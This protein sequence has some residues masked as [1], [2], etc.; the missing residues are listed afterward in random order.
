MTRGRRLIGGVVASFGAVGAGSVASL[1]VAPVMFHH[2]GPAL[3]GVWVAVTALTSVALF[4]DLG[5]GNG[6]LTCLAAHRHAPAGATAPHTVAVA[7]LALAGTAAALLTGVVV[8]GVAV[9]V[10]PLFGV[11]DPTLG[12]RAA[13]VLV[14]CFGAF[15]VNLPLSLIAKIQLAMQDTARSAA[16][17]AGTAA[18]TVLTVGG[19]SAAGL[20][21]L[22]F[23]AAAATAAPIGNLVNT[24]HY[25]TWVRPDLRPR[26]WTLD[27]DLAGG[28]LRLSARYFTL[29][30]L[31]STASSIDG[32]LVARWLGPVAAAHYGVTV[33]MFILLNLIVTVVNAPLW[34]ANA[35]ALAR[36]DLPWVRRT[37]RRMCLLSAAVV[38]TAAVALVATS[39]VLLAAWIRSP[40][41]HGL[42][43]VAVA[44]LA[45]WPALLAVVS[46]MLMVQ[47]SAGILAPQLA[48]WGGYLLLSLPAKAFLVRHLGLTGV[49]LGS[50]LA[51]TVTVL[52]ACVAGYHGVVTRR[53]GQHR[54]A[55]TTTARPAHEPAMAGPGQSARGNTCS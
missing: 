6:L 13:Q 5:L 11:T 41:F 35:E 54:R 24:L 39:D 15:A 25:F 53:P 26:S 55:T 48:G 3:F 23:I 42:P 8:V 33:R 1:I 38:G 18:W 14:V 36:G 16:W 22:A 27:P 9:P 4:A 47:N 40:Q 44:L 34:P 43:T 2:L 49:P 50:A 51:F 46:P 17:S 31:T 30:L 45:A 37:T 12:T 20:G 19:A 32:Y 21:P 29:S 28:L 7:Y 10:G 52:P